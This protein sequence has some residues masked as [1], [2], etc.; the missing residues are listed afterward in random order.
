MPLRI[1][2]EKIVVEV[3]AEWKNDIFDETSLEKTYI[4]ENDLNGLVAKGGLTA[5]QEK[6]SVGG[7]VFDTLDSQDAL[8][9]LA[10]EGDYTLARDEVVENL[11]LARSVRAL[12]LNISLP[13]SNVDQP[14]SFQGETAAF[15]AGGGC[16]LIHSISW[17]EG[18]LN[19]AFLFYSVIFGL[20]VFIMG[21]KYGLNRF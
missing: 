12:N 19:A 15:V 13:D 21:W 14:A 20:F 3:K 4:I 10:L 8:I 18:A 9:D 2:E 1:G 16:S 11:G 7:N 6:L 17:K 5:L